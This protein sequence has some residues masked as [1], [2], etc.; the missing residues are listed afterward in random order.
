[1]VLQ[2]AGLQEY[3]PDIGYVRA[4]ETSETAAQS[5]SNG[6]SHS[7]LLLPIDAHI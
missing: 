7:M 2:A 4:R 5:L 6:H 3:I 1:M